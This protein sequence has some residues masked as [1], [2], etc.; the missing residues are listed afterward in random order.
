MAQHV[1]PVWV[2]RLSVSPLRRFV[3]NPQKIFG[4]CV[5]K[6]TTVLDVGCAMGFFTLP[7][8]R[9]VGSA[10]KVVCVDLQER[11]ISSLR[12]RALRAGLADRI[13]PR[14]CSSDSLCLDGLDSSIDFALV[15][16][17][18]HEVPDVGTFF[19]ELSQALK[20][21]A[22]VLFVEPKGHVSAEEFEKYLSLDKEVTFIELDHPRV[23]GCR[24]VL[25]T[26]QTPK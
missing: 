23:L 6:G 1:C 18:A 26:K 19:R 5:Q 3:H 2:G 25:L 11:M 10:G 20:P 7:M 24:A 15:F 14:L 8:A 17:V 22:S 4:R 13:E 16:A 12:Q 21:G 9:F